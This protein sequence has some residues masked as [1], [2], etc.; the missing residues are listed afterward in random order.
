MAA[1]F[2][3]LAT[4]DGKATTTASSSTSLVPEAIQ[5]HS[6]LRIDFINGATVIAHPSSSSASTAVATTTNSTANAIDLD[7][8]G[9]SDTSRNAY[10]LL[11]YQTVQTQRQDDEYAPTATTNALLLVLASERQ[12]RRGHQDMSVR[13]DLGIWDCR[14]IANEDDENNNKTSSISSSS[15]LAAM[16][17]RRVV[18]NNDRFKLSGGSSSSSSNNTIG[19]R[20]EKKEET[21][22]RA[23]VSDSTIQQQN[24]ILHPP[25]MV[26]VV[27]MSDVSEIQQQVERMK[28]VI[29]NI[30]DDNISGGGNDAPYDD[31]SGKSHTTSVRALKNTIFG[32]AAMIND[33]T[34]TPSSAPPTSEDKRIALILAV[35]VPPSTTPSSSTNAAEEYKER[36][37]R[38]LILYHLHKFSMEVD[39][40]LCFV[41]REGGGSMELRSSSSEGGE[42]TNMATYLP[43]MSIDEFSKVIRRVALGLP[44]VEVDIIAATEDEEDNGDEAAKDDSN[45]DTPL[46]ISTTWDAVTDDLNVALPPRSSSSGRPSAIVIGEERAKTAGNGDEEWLSELAYSM[47]ISSDAASS[48]SAPAP[49]T[50]PKAEQPGKE[51]KPA[52]KKR[53]TRASSSSTRDKDAKPKD[54]KEVMNFFGNLIKK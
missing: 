28:G 52:V 3:A 27:D 48:S 22:Y 19:D 50:T 23:E 16:L 51:T 17:L 2:A 24:Q 7:I 35:I 12:K 10:S 26:M 45:E 4:K 34:S 15:S 13:P 6:H 41:R 8:G 21:T 42:D 40:T 1:L 54:Q 37:A 18:L 9:G 14:I 20:E 29:V 53:V 33:P 39:C 46:H 49:S 47:G 5:L 11:S 43:S 32:S 38:D 25:P 31:G 44:P 36:R 30:Y